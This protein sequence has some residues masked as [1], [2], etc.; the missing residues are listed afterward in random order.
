MGSIGALSPTWGHLRHR[1]QTP[2][3]LG[4][5]CHIKHSTLTLQDV[6]ACNKMTCGV[7][8]ILFCWVCCKD[9]SNLRN[10]YDH[11]N[12]RSSRCYGQL[13]AGVPGH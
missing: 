2:D 4:A 9:L 3:S 11:F 7:C 13:F 12:D 5:Q 1:Q 10:G 8:K 6:H